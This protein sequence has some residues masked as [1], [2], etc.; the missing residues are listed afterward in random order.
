[1]LQWTWK[2]TLIELYA[3]TTAK[4]LT[5]K[6]TPDNFFK[7][8]SIANIIQET[9]QKLDD[10]DKRGRAAIIDDPKYRDH[11]PDSTTSINEVVRNY[12]QKLQKLFH[13]MQEVQSRLSHGPFEVFELPNKE[14]LFLRTTDLPTKDAEP[15]RYAL[16]A[17]E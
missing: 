16:F 17:K 15:C 14:S 8:E 11:K 5:Y 12:Y 6:Y 13:R 2:N 1:M 10:T 4:V 9:I 3:R 7:E